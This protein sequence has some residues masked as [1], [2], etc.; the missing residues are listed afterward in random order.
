MARLKSHQHLLLGTEPVL[1]SDD[2]GCGERPLPEFSPIFIYLIS[3]F[4]SVSAVVIHCDICFVN[5]IKEVWTR[6]IDCSLQHCNLAWMSC[7]SCL[8]PSTAMSSVNCGL[9]LS[10]KN[11]SNYYFSPQCNSAH[12]ARVIYYLIVSIN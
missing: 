5:N 4:A 6:V 8:Y 11:A 2:G 1:Y 7:K 12:V 3:G 10:R 9:L